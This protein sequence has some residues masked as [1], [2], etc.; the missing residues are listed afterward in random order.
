VD[1]ANAAS[2]SLTQPASVFLSSGASS[3][4][5]NPGPFITLNGELR[6]GGIDARVILTNNAR[7]THVASSD[8]TVDVVLLPAGQ[9]IQIAKQPPQGGV[10]GNPHIYL[11]FHD[12]AGGDLSTPIYLGRCVQGLKDTSLNFDLPTDVDLQV[13]SGSC[14]NSP[15][16]YITLNGEMRLGGLCGR[17]IFSNNARL[18]HVAAS[19]VV[20]DVVL[21]PEGSSLTFAKQPP[22]GGAGG[23]PY[24]W[25][26]FLNGGGADLGDPIFLGRC[27]QLGR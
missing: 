9:S 26:Q 27:N 14:S 3:C 21:L 13:T 2:T 25:V 18:T 5:N 20:V 23:N 19:D 10:G 22:Q 24:I 15:G 6:L 16:P 11:Q 1:P 4:S 17:L 7:F 12:C 8:L